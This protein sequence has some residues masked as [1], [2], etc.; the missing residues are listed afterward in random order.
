MTSHKKGRKSKRAKRTINAPRRRKTKRQRP[1][2]PKSGPAAPLPTSESKT[3]PGVQELDAQFGAMRAT[4]LRTLRRMLII[5]EAANTCVLA[6]RHHEGVDDDIDV[7]TT[8][9]NSVVN[10]TGAEMVKLREVIEVLPEGGA[11]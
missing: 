4:L 3:P 1:T 7:A 6:M 9:R 11:S 10:R 8:L 2:V 5:R